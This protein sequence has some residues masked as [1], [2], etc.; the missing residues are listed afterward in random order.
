MWTVTF[1]GV[2]A[3]VPD[4]KGLPVIATLLAQPHH[5]FSVADLAGTAPPDRG[6]PVL[7]RRALL[8]YRS[9]IRGPGCGDR[10]R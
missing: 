4:A 7:D 5:A 8:S 9:R 1:R 2:E 10:R 6:E 3:V